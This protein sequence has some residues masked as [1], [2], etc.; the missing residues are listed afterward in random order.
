VLSDPEL[1]H[2][3]EP[4]WERLA[5]V[6][7][8]CSRRVNP[9]D[10]AGSLR[11]S[12]LDPAPLDAPLEDQLRHIAAG[13]LA[14]LG[15]SWRRSLDPMGGG[16]LVYWFPDLPGTGG[17]AQA[18]TLGLFD[19]LDRPP[20]DGWVGVVREDRQARA[21]SYLVGW[22]PPSLTAM[23]GAGVAAAGG[24]SLAWW[25]EMPSDLRALVRR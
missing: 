19:A 10:P 8:W 25:D 16:R 2:G 23:A 13:R 1:G 3:P 24:G 4:F 11:T 15:R 5:E 18:A 20:W 21:P 17:A 7:A 22:V 12:L 6:V 14:V 9:A